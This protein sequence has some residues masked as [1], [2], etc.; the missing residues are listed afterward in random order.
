[1]RKIVLGV[2]GALVAIPI[3][4]IVIL[5]DSAE[6][7]LRA[8][9]AQEDAASVVL[10]DDVGALP[11][12]SPATDVREEQL[13]NA[14]IVIDAA[15]GA[16]LPLKAQVIGVMTA[17]GESGLRNLDHGDEG[18]GVT[19]PDGTPTCSLGIFQQQWCL[20]N[21]LGEPVWGTRDQVT[22]PAYASRTFYKR[23]ADVDG[24]QDLEP[25]FAA[26]AV[27]RNADPYHY[28]K[29]WEPATTIVAALTGVELGADAVVPEGQCGI[30]AAAGTGQ[31]TSGG[32]P[33]PWGGYQN[34]QIPPE[35]LKALPWDTAHSL[36][37]DAADALTRLN[38]AYRDDHGGNNIAITDSYRTL[39]EQYAIKAAK[40][41]LA[42][43]PGT[44][45]HGWGLAV[46]FANMG[47]HST[48][49]YQWMSANGPAYGWINP[50]W[51][52]PTGSKPEAWHWEYMGDTDEA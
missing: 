43:T 31:Y 36:R 20:T 7:C 26:N 9:A 35:A 37:P 46:D 23:L 15:R 8:S 19:N 40:P 5:G 29:Y 48:F 41:D 33:A 39:E 18:D 22:D 50:D 25:T 2:I 52:L 14:V 11:G 27:Q 42:A 13:T 51:A 21:N 28:E 24:W 38:N 49:D 32:G 4:V 34:G 6:A 44:S 17:L 3:L 45:N 47:V 10:P 1:M 16:S 30:A 12:L